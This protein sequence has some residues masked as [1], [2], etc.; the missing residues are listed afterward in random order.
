ML[1]FRS[2]IRGIAVRLPVIV[3]FGGINAAGRSSSHHGY[4]RM[5]I[6][7]LPEAVASQ[8]WASLAALGDQSWDGSEAMREALAAGTLIRRIESHHFDVDAV[9]WNRRMVAH[10]EDFPMSFRTQHKHLPE[11]IPPGWNITPVD[12]LHVHVEIDQGMM[13]LL[14]THR[15]A[16]VKAA[17][18]L[19]TGFDPG[20]LYQAR[21]HPRG[22][23]MAVYAASDAIAS[24]GI[25]WEVLQSMVAADQVSVYA[26]SGMSQLDANGN[27]GLVKARYN[28]R[29]V[30]SKFCPFG[31]AEMPA[32]FINAYVLGS[33]G[34][35]GT[36]MGACASFL[37]NLRQG[38]SDIQSGRSRIVIVGNS[39]API[40]PEVMDG[41]AAM[42]ALAS[43]RELRE[44]DGRSDEQEPD[45][46]RACRPFGENCGFTIAESA[47]MV[48]LFDDEL[49]METGA[50]LYGSVSDVFINADGHKKSI[51]APGVGNYITVAKAMAAAR[52]LVGEEALRTGG[53][54]QAHGTGTPQNRITESHILNQVA[55]T[56]GIE[57]WPVGAV[58]AFIGHSIGAAAGDQLVNT[59]GVW[60]HGLLPGIATIDGVADDVH[61]SHLDISSSHRELDPA[62]QAYAI[63]NAKGFGGNNASATVLS[64][65]QTRT[66]LEKRYG[67]RDWQVWGER[68]EAVVAQAASYESQALAGEARPIYKFDHNVLGSDDVEMAADRLTLGNGAV[69]I[70]LLLPN[71]Y[72]DLV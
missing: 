12:D 36:S 42:G 23:Q 51:A 3:G 20:K 1:F 69:E 45:Y 53:L 63:I 56:F 8:T 15:Q 65:G 33:L 9:A 10:S 50:S 46:R 67:S 66:M 61:D 18:Q 19:P 14:P 70:D 59:L 26:G 68:N 16:A 64:P 21:S 24:T 41:Y 13:F 54:V 58:K 72:A 44:L 35:T 11:V 48:V 25:S 5:V 62:S 34:T 71:Q 55:Q 32:D 4:R 40:T 28:G 47:Q 31:F 43:D 22:L 37:Y 29:K 2:T 52:N 27:G 57:R 60:E 49:A 7:A 6:D 30:T 17:G 39:E 38:I